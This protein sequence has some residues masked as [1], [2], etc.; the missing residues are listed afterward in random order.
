MLAPVQGS[1]EVLFR[2][3]PVDGKQHI[4][5]LQWMEGIVKHERAS[6]KDVLALAGGKHVQHFSDK[7]ETPEWMQERAENLQSDSSNG[8][9]TR[10][11]KRRSSSEPLDDE[12]FPSMTPLRWMHGMVKNVES[13]SSKDALASTMCAGGKHVQH[14]PLHKSK[15][16]CA[17]GSLTR[18]DDGKPRLSLP[19]RASSEPAMPAQF[20]IDVERTSSD[21]ELFPS[22]IFD[23][24]PEQNIQTDG[25]FRGIFK[26]VL[27][28]AMPDGKHV[29][30]FPPHK[31][32]TPEWMH[33]RV[34]NLQS[35]SSNA[36]LTMHD[37]KPRISLPS[38]DFMPRQI[39]DPSPVA[40]TRPKPKHVMLSGRF[41]KDR[42]AD[43]RTV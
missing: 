29:R 8:S 34:E 25:W 31:S 4:Q 3:M 38:S 22:M 13:A 11:G 21:D 23:A 19:W 5:P 14:F 26:N 28:L 43:N 20:F 18:N 42:F 37:E 40:Y 27:A 16:D 36:S 32:E 12:L 24:K 39:S 35:G 30:H 10:D 2:T 17:N 9:P 33:K 6:S 15:S 1:K 41:V 7:S